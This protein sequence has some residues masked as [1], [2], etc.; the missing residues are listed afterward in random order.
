MIREKG[1]RKSGP[2]GSS[3]GLRSTGA[4]KTEACRWRTQRLSRSSFSARCAPFPTSASSPNRQDRIAAGEHPPPGF[5]C[6]CH[7]RSRGRATEMQSKSRGQFVHSDRQSRS[8]STTGIACQSLCPAEPPM[9]PLCPGQHGRGP[10]LCFLHI[11]IL[12]STLGHRHGLGSNFFHAK[13]RIR[14]NSTLTVDGTVIIPM[15]LQKK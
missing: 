1:K 14:V 12:W 9:S 2:P 10:A 11:P 5:S 6:L 3:I 7:R 8:R 15:V 13:N 4:Q